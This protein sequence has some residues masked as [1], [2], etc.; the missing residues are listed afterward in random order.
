MFLQTDL[1]IQVKKDENDDTCIHPFAVSKDAKTVY[2][3]FMYNRELPRPPRASFPATNVEFIGSLRDE[4]VAVMNESLDLINKQGSVI[5][6]VYTGFGKTF[7]AIKL[8]T[9]IRLPTLIIIHRVVLAKQ[10]KDAITKFCKNPKVCIVE[11][12]NEIDRTADFVIMNATNIP[13]RDISAYSHIGL[14]IVDEAHLI[15]AEG[16]SQCMTC[17]LPRY[18]IGLSATPYRL[19]GLD[20]LL[21]L[22]FG[23]KKVIREMWHPHK[24]FRVTTHFRPEVR[25]M[26][27]GR[28]DWNYII[29]QQSMHEGRNRLICDIVRRHPSRVFLVLTKRVAQ[30]RLLIQSLTDQGEKVTSLVGSQ[31][32]YD[33]HARVLVG[34]SSKAGVGFDHPRLDSLI[35]ACDIEAYFVQYLGRIFRRKD[36]EPMIFD[37]VDEHPVLEK[38]FRTRRSVYLK[39]GGTLADYR[40]V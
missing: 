5:I 18:V 26:A 2:V 15:M 23:A 16:L 21:T 39:H 14:V 10:W 40:A 24:V 17:L 9:L 25:K 3:P 19:D 1:T 13:K 6:A 37:I 38:H 30:A 36:A 22:Y 12:G 34:T 8:S 27:N 33:P 4:Q 35:L 20:R 31:Q 11:S 29:E 28:L 7:T 32:T